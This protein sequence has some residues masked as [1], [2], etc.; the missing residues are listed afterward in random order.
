PGMARPGRRDGQG[1]D[2]VG[3]GGQ[4]PH[5]PGGKGSNRG[6]LVD[7]RGVP[8]SIVPNGANTHDAKPLAATLDGIAVGRP[9]E[10]SPQQGPC[11]DAGQVGGP[12]RRE[13]GERGYIPRV[14]PRGEEIAEMDKNPDFKARRWVVEVCHSWFDRSRK[15]LV[16]HEK[17]GRSH[18]GWLMLAASAIVLRK[19]KRSGEYYLWI[20]SKNYQWVVQ[21]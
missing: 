16:R 7:G 18:L 9:G 4:G 19:N 1:T 6:L 2:G 10:G 20:S 21:L 13:V 14:R 15:L 8:L 17:M 5:R 11:L 3:A 12:A